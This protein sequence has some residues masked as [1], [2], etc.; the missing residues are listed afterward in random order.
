[1]N[2]LYTPDYGISEDLDYYV[3]TEAA[4]EVLKLEDVESRM[5]L[6][7]DADEESVINSQI[8]AIRIHLEKILGIS[9]VSSQTI[10]AYWKRFGKRLK[11]PLGPVKSI[12]SVSIV[13]QAD[14]TETAF[15]VNEDFWIE[16]VKDKTINFN[17][18]Y[19][20]NSYG[21]KVVYVVGQT[22]SSIIALAKDAILSELLE[23]FHQRSNPDE[24]VYTLGKIAMSKLHPFRKF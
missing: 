14:G 4:S 12:T 2:L 1:M 16:G 17:T 15:T 8:K 23:W 18:I 20:A 3:S 11:L 9:L 19:A 21:V 24:A 5:N 22:D 13:S 6:D 7:A 10:T